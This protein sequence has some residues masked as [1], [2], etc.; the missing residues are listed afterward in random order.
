MATIRDAS[1]NPIHSDV[2]TPRPTS[3]PFLPQDPNRISVEDI[4]RMIDSRINLAN[5]AA[6]AASVE[7]EMNN[8]R[9]QTYRAV[10][11]GAAGLV[12]GTTATLGVSALVRRS[13]A[14]RAMAGGK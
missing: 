6:S 7:K 12:V 11:Y 5:A 14:R 13:R 1:G 4:E 9:K 8:R 10:A 3:V 2:A